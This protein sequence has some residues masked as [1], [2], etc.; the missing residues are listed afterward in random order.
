MIMYS[1]LYYLGYRHLL[2]AT[3]LKSQNLWLATAFKILKQK[4]ELW[5]KDSKYIVSEQA[6]FSGLSLCVFNKSIFLL[7]YLSLTLSPWFFLTA[8]HI[9][10]ELKLVLQHHCKVSG[11]DAMIKIQQLKFVQPV[12]Q[13]NHFCTPQHV[14]VSQNMANGQSLPQVTDKTSNI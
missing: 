1:Y 11:T 6:F 7:I 3:L 14:Y 12:F 2:R 8:Q 4:N 9:Q 10:A 5:L 13:R